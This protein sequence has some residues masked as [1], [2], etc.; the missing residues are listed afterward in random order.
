MCEVR[1]KFRSIIYS[2][3]ICRYSREKENRLQLTKY[4]TCNNNFRREKKNSR[5]I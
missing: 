4:V 3:Y 5:D 1:G 2:L